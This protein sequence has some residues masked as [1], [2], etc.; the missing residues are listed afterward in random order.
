MVSD[1][2]I[3]K[4]YG[5]RNME[6]SMDLLD[7]GNYEQ[8]IEKGYTHFFYGGNQRS[9]N[10]WKNVLLH[11]SRAEDCGV[12]SP[13]FRQLSEEEKI[14]CKYWLINSRRI[15]FGWDWVHQTG[16]WMAEHI[17]KVNT[18]VMIG[19]GAAFDFHTGWSSRR[20]GGC[21]RVSW[22]FFGF[23]RNQEGSGSAIWKNNPL[24]IIKVLGQLLGCISIFVEII[25]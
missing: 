5:H 9:Q 8:V 14:S 2:W 13:P 3:G 10:Y 22:V 1:V 15:S 7:A 21:S 17:K 16:R 19:V 12:F 25:F 20:H 24:F 18:R 11:V 4:L 6:R 23:L